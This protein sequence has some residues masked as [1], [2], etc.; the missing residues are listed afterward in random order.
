MPFRPAQCPS[1]QKNIQIPDDVDTALCMY[2]GE[3]IFFQASHG[4]T[5]PDVANLLG[6]A[7]TAVAGLNFEEAEKYY[8]RVLEIDP[9]ISEAW[10]GKGKAAGWQS[11]LGN[12]RINETVVA[13][14][15]AIATS[16]SDD[17]EN[18]ILDCFTDINNLS[19]ELHTMARK[20][21]E[22]FISL[23]NSWT[24][25]LDRTF[26]LI[27]ILEETADWS[28]E[29]KTNLE[30]IVFL[31][32]LCIN[33]IAYTDPFDNNASKAW[34]LTP[35][36]ETIMREKM[37]NATTKIQAL[38]PSY[39]P[40]IAEAVKPESSCFVVTATMGDENHPHVVTM[41]NFRDEYLLKRG[42]GITFVKAYYL[43][44][45]KVAHLISKNIVLRYLSYLC[46]VVPATFGARL[47]CKWK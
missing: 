11:T 16:S 23:P 10:F 20:H 45:P 5:G 34:H 6:L 47:L 18:I 31:S 24:D 32:K 43:H 44:G 30:N 28:P 25:Y 40:P 15:H 19:V 7:R 37:N 1:C 12:M 2:C 39:T 42:W 36:F 46:I 27:D 41:R 26:M 29:S 21:M 33:G 22:E 13:F 8:A 14:K 4:T 35:E 3:Q 9:T 17:K 38:D